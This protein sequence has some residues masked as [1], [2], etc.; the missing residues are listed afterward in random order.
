MNDDVGAEFHRPQL[1]RRRH[2][3]IDR[4][5]RTGRMGRAGCRGDIGDGEPRIGRHFDQHERR[6][7][8]LDR[9]AQRRGIG[10][11][12][13]F[14]GMIVACAELAQKHRGSPINAGL[15]DNRPSGWNRSQNRRDC[16]HSGR[17]CNRARDTFEFCEQRVEFAQDRRIVAPIDM[18]AG[19]RPVRGVAGESGRRLDRRHDS[20][21]CRVDDAVGARKQCFDMQSFVVPGGIGHSFAIFKWRVNRISIRSQIRRNTSTISRYRIAAHK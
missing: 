7:G 10:R 9:C 6:T 2:R 16:S 8:R 12:D 3:R 14:Q 19:N 11:I 5:A 1:D 13:F 4:Q 21:G 15:R 20:A 17:K 18:R